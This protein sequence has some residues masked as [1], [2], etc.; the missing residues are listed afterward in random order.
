MLLQ[1]VASTANS[2]PLP[3]WAAS[4]GL[5]ADFGSFCRRI[6]DEVSPKNASAIW[7]RASRL[8]QR[9]PK[10]GDWILRGICR[11][12]SVTRQVSVSSRRR[13]CGM[14]A[15][16][17]AVLR[18]RRR[19]RQGVAASLGDRLK[20]LGRQAGLV[21]PPAAADPSARSRGARPPCRDRGAFRSLCGSVCQRVEP[22]VG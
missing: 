15:V 8:G 19:V 22:T 16:P 5:S 6:P 13:C 2:P 3:Y 1:S 12:S 10:I 17:G 7:L 18:G 14:S 21:R 4:L 20:T 11:R 9:F